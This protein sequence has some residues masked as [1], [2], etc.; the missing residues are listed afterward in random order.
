MSDLKEEIVRLEQQNVINEET[1]W[2]KCRKMPN[3]KASEHDGVE[4]SG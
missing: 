4:G 3:W 2:K 1:V